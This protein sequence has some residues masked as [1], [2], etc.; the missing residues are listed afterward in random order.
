M[1]EIDILYKNGVQLQNTT[2]EE[3]LK[4]EPGQV[5]YFVPKDG[6]DQ[7]SSIL[8]MKF[9][10]FLRKLHED[11]NVKLFIAP[12]ENKLLIGN[13]AGRSPKEV[14]IPYKVIVSNRNTIAGFAAEYF[15]DDI[16]DIMSRIPSSV[17]SFG[18]SILPIEPMIIHID[19]NN[20]LPVVQQT[21]IST[22]EV[23]NAYYT[24]LLPSQ[25]QKETDRL[26]LISDYEVKIRQMLWDIDYLNMGDEINIKSIVDD[27]IAKKEKQLEY[28][29]SI[30][31]SV[32]QKSGNVDCDIYVGDGIKLEFKAI[33][34]A[35]YM[36]FLMLEN[37]LKINDVTD[38]FIELIQKIYNR[39]PDK[40]YKDGGLLYS[41][42][43]RPSTMRGYISEI[44]RAVV[45]AIP[46]GRIGYRFSIVTEERNHPYIIKASTEEIR[47]Q[48]KEL[49]GL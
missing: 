36:T 41:N 13:F 9:F 7:R 15:G 25:P 43:M 40:S 31:A 49:F 10:Q 44:N 11:N 4:I 23:P 48:I 6:M 14:E 8:I 24:E 30:K 32:R 19:N 33:H 37:G 26:K 16:N 3:L 29:L 2:P 46:G 34:K 38:E 12:T 20:N 18:I 45:K 5:V 39:L 1:L 17:S 28:K 42:Q 47:N 22:T 35:L 27:I 21:D